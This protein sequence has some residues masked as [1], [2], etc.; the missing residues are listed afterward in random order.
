M[1]SVNCTRK[2]LRT[3]QIAVR[4]TI[5]KVA[6]LYTGKPQK[7]HDVV[8]L[9]PQET[10]DRSTQAD[11]CPQTG[12]DIEEKIWGSTRRIPDFALRQ[13]A[14]KHLAASKGDRCWVVDKLE[15]SFNCAHIIQFFDGS[16]HVIRVPA[17][18]TEGRW[19]ADDATAFQSQAQTMMFIKRNTKVPIPEVL[20]YNASVENELGHPYI[21]MSFIEGVPA[22]E[23]WNDDL[24]D[25]ELEDS[26]Q[27]ILK[28]IAQALAELQHLSF[29][30]AGMLYFEH[31]E[32][33]NSRVGPALE[34]DDGDI[35]DPQ[36]G[37]KHQTTMRSEYT[38][39]KKSLNARLDRWWNDK[40]LSGVSDTDPGKQSCIAVA[41]VLG[42]MIDMLPRSIDAGF[43]EEPE[44]T[45]LPAEANE[46]EP[47]ACDDDAQFALEQHSDAKNEDKDVNPPETFVL[48]PPDL[49][50]QNIMMDPTTLTVTG[51]I[52]WD[53]TVTYPRFTGWSMFPLFLTRD[54]VDG[55]AFDPDDDNA[56]ED[57][58]RWRKD[59]AS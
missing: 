53:W 10:P 34:V 52:G 57:L 17:C 40:N 5:R 36:Q 23:I 26:R 30:A 51:F 12:E 4:K 6:T 59:Y 31:D 56:P 9:L 11:A 8:A 16:K 2:A 49:D 54:Y 32:D 18:G 24:E 44:F 38:D 28:S 46:D 15:G 20:G 13:I 55:Y 19:T 37:Y 58:E 48:A 35:R 3:V 21:L 50:W 14:R 45:I 33:D 25:D 22:H 1:S 41:V 39:T 7:N 27:C 42:M 47:S 43:E 29:P